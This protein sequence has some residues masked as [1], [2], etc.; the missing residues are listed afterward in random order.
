MLSPT[1]RTAEFGETAVPLFDRAVI[2]AT[3]QL[4]D[5]WFGLRMAIGLRRLVTM[6]LPLDAGIDVEHWG[7]RMRLHPHGSICE[8]LT[9]FTPQMFDTAER[10]KLAHGVMGTL[11]RGRRFS[12][13]DIGAHVG[14][15][16]LFI[17]AIARGRADIVA[18]EP[19]PVSLARLRFNVAANPMI[20]V[21]IQPVALGERSE[22][23]ALDINPINR[24]G[25]RT[26]PAVAGDTHIV[27]CLT[28]CDL[29]RNERVERIDALKIDVE[30]AESSILLPFFQSAPASL[31]PDMIIIE[32][33]QLL[34]ELEMRGYKVTDRT[35]S[36]VILERRSQ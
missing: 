31:W 14:V 25:T 16:S 9:L 34:P 27:P 19:E 12:F 29:L 36:N 26:R 23:I 13:I 24:G 3:T 33:D 22:S 30:G 17:A 4:P 18:I 28:L 21:N 20:K 11:A 5:N 7:I 15:Y 35:R 6:R 10:T 8:K 1:I 32:G 2:S